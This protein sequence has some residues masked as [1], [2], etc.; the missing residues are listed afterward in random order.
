[1]EEKIT[2][3]K[4]IADSMSPLIFLELLFE[5]RKN[6]TR[7]I[8]YFLLSAGAIIT[9]FYMQLS[10]HESSREWLFTALIVIKIGRAHV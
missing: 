8:I 9:L 3:I 2:R 6:S 7:L 1:M 5:L 10:S 4:Q